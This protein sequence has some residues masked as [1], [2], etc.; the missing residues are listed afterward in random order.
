MSASKYRLYFLL[1][2][3]AH[4]LRTESD[5]ALME[6]AG[7]TTAQA[8]V[9]RIVADGEN[10]NQ[11]QLASVLQQRESAI[12]AMIARLENANLM[13]RLRSPSD[14]RAWVLEVTQQGQQALQ[15]IEKPFKDINRKIDGALQDLTS[16]QVAD[17]LTAL[18][19][20]GKGVPLD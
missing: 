13:R 11:R 12:T 19:N 5:N 18:I 8:S 10:I 15:A 3:A 2:R 20:A 6:A 4:K 7:I 16:Q 9:L 1:Q 17:V 14:G